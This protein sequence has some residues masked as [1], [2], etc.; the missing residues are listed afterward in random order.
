LCQLSTADRQYK[1]EKYH[2]IYIAIKFLITHD[3]SR[4]QLLVN[5]TYERETTT[6]DAATREHQSPM[7]VDQSWIDGY[8][9]VS[10][11]IHP[12]TPACP[13]DSTTIFY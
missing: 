7:V 11:G 5:T 13:G 6:L 1:I 9:R 8:L 3:V 10:M 12:S 2:H 4:A